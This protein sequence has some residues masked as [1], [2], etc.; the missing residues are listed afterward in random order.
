MSQGE[1]RLFDREFSE[2]F[3]SDLLGVIIKYEV[4]TE[5]LIAK[6]LIGE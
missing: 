3:G 4:H 6:M 1:L 5:E 2:F